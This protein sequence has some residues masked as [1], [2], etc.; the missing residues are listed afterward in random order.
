MKLVPSI[1]L[2][3]VRGTAAAGDVGQ[4]AANP[5]PKIS[6]WFRTAKSPSGTA[7]RDEADGHR[8]GVPIK[9][10]GENPRSSSDRGG[11]RRTA[12]TSA[13]LIHQDLRSLHLIWD[14]PVVRDNPTGG[15][16]WSGCR[17]RT[18]SCWCAVSRLAKKLA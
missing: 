18:A 12:T 11:P 5:D 2:S 15:A 10:A 4:I 17:R 16:Q 8:E 6:T 9:F 1:A 3:S 14:G 7:C 13:L